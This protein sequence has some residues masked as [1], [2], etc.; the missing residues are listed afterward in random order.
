MCKRVNNVFFSVSN[1]NVVCSINNKEYVVKN[2]KQL[3]TLLKTNNITTNNSNIFC[4]SSVEF[5]NEDGMLAGQADE[6]IDE[7][8]VSI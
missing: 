6:L 2:V 1:S 8:L 7:A 5:C 4:S 3:V